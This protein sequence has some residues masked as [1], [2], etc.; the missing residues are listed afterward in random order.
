[1]NIKDKKKVKLTTV[2]PFNYFM[3]EGK[4]FQ[5]TN[6]TLSS[7]SICLRHNCDT[8]KS[9]SVILSFEIKVIPLTIQEVAYLDSERKTNK[10]SR[11]KS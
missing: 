6:R 1:M 8:D 9:S 3:F 10:V 2:S 7:N 11:R 4:V 5:K